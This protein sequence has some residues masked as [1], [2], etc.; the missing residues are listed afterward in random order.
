[1]AFV[2]LHFAPKKLKMA[3]NSSIRAQD[4]PKE[5]QDV[6]Q[7]AQDGFE[8]VS[9]SPERLEHILAAPF[10]VTVSIADIGDYF[11]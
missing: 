11:V 3:Q 10:F 8:M 2:R 1:M 4:G 9:D 7:R 5:A 6:R